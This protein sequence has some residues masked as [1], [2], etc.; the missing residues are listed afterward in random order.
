MNRGFV[1]RC[2]VEHCGQVS[3]ESM[4]ALQESRHKAVSE[5]A[6]ETL[7]LLEHNKVI[8]LGKNGRDENLLY[9]KD[10]LAARG[11]ELLRSSRGGDITY[12][13]PGQLVV[14]PILRL[15]PHE[16]DLRQYVTRLEQI[17]IRTAAD[18]GVKAG[19]VDGLRGIWV[20]NEKLGAIGVRMSR[21]VTMHGFAL[22]ITTDLSDFELIIPCG[23][24]DRG[25][26]SLSKLL[27]RPPTIKEVEMRVIK[28][29]AD[30]F[31]RDLDEYKH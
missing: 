31:E 21:W 14:Y 1:N 25:V 3:Y 19:P 18:F 17:M 5:G 20:G 8:T 23:L 9:S 24:K 15:Q 28:H 2:R 22:N 16:Q 10:D 11:I 27:S 29:F 4:L 12:H 6:P 13:G 26:T 7:F 30:L